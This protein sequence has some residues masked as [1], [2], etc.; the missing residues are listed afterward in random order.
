M[1]RFIAGLLLGIVLGLPAFADLPPRPEA[2]RADIPA[3]TRASAPGQ[4]T[5]AYYNACSGWLWVWGT[6]ISRVG[7][8]FDLAEDCGLSP[9]QLC[10]NTS[11]S[12]W[13]YCFE[14][15]GYGHTVSYEMYE[16]DSMN[17]TVGEP[18]GALLNQELMEG[19]VTYPGLGM[20]SGD[21]VVI[22][23]WGNGSMMPYTDN[24]QFNQ[25]VGCGPIPDKT[26]SWWFGYFSG[27][28]VCPPEDHFHDNAG[29]CNLMM[30]A[31]FSCE[32]T[33][34]ELTSWGKIKQLF[35]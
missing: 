10:E 9:G 35:R 2:I 31:T 6:T 14:P 21:R 23:G 25:D 26:R 20:T 27:S 11:F 12:W 15:P 34:T 29:P 8:I 32:T 13:W 33:Q 22:I 24:T 28:N 30:D 3:R 1:P 5:L 17:C 7:V 4:C 19:W 16:V 18:L